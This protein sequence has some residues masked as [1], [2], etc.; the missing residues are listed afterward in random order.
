MVEDAEPQAGASARTKGGRKG[1]MTQ[2]A[3]NKKHLK[4]SHTL[5]DTLTNALC[6]TIDT[7]G[8]HNINYLVLDIIREYLTFHQVW[9]KIENRLT[10]KA[11]KTSHR[12]ALISQLGDI[13][14]FHSNTRKLI[15]EIQSIQTK[16]SLLGKPFANNTLFLA[17]QKCTICHPVYKETVTTVHQ[18]DFITL[19]IALRFHQTAVESIPMQK[20]DPQ[21]A[22]TRIA[23][24][25][26]Q[27]RQAEETKMGNNN[28][29]PKNTSRSQQIQCWVCKQ[30]GHGIRHC[31]A[32][33]TIPKDSPF[34]KFK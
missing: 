4:W 33:V 28:A 26:N 6:R 24:S 32:S 22:S 3:Y 5:N 13:K 1:K 7:T 31:D 30:T 2:G 21:Q 20:I 8:E 27:D 12:L 14:M 11:T 10:N 23:G 25:D 29:S 34:A 17:L 9:R 15:Q 18:I 16:S 19:A